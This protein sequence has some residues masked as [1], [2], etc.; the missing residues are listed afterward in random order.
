MDI[1]QSL[2]WRQGVL[3]RDRDK[4][5]KVRSRLMLRRP[6]KERVTTLSNVSYCK[7]GRVHGNSRGNSFYAVG[8]MIV[9]IK[10]N[11]NTNLVLK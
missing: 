10:N 11:P 4:L 2:S 6:K 5:R 8:T 3:R 7:Y 9:P 1:L